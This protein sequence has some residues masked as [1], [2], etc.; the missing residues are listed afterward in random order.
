MVIRPNSTWSLKTIESFLGEQLIPIRLA[1]IAPNTRPV[2]CSLWYLHAEGVL[3]CATQRT[4][5]VAS[6]LALHP[7]CGFE[8]APEAMPY[9]GVRGQGKVAISQ[10]RGVDVLERLIDRYLGNRETDFARWLLKRASN[11]VAIKIEPTWI[12]AW[13]FS[14][15]MKSSHRAAARAGSGGC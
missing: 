12:T 14:P 3:W 11:E 1:C 13:D 8:V 15:R 4:A 5:K 7:I 9:K 10:E 6:Y 2:V